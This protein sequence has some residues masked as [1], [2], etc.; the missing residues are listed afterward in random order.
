MT[1]PARLRFALAATLALAACGGHTGPKAVLQTYLEAEQ[2]GRF[3]AAH[4]LLTP[5]DQQARSLDAYVAEHLSAGPI[6][7]A[8]A[9]RTQF[10]LG[11]VST[12]A[13]HVVVDVR[14]THEDMKAVEAGLGG[15]PT[16]RIDSSP[17]PAAAM[18]AYV[19]Q[20]LEA[21]AFPRVTEAIPYAL[22]EEGGTWHV[23]LGLDRQDAAIALAR[24][25]L[26]AMDKGQDAAAVAAWTKVLD[27]PPDPSGVVANVQQRARNALADLDAR[28][29]EH[30]AP[31]DATTP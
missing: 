8:V 12:H 21:Q 25:A 15:V 16:D 27:L 30:T 22:R 19:Q 18:Y 11:D 9:R 6:W 5:T 4:A 3:E 31:P 29:S 28:A 24:E 7:L 20:T 13:D 2:S 1:A 23:W 14:A 10:T 17:D 26:V